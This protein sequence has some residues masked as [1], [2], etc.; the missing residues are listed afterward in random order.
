VATPQ[1]E[2]GYTRLA[3]E[4]LDEFISAGLTSR[5]W[6]VLMAIVRKTYGYNKT[7]DDIGLSQ[8]SEMTGIA[9]G[10]VSVAVRELESMKIINRKMGVFGHN[11]SINKKYK[12]WNLEAKSVTDSVTVT[13]SVTVTKSVTEGLPNQYIGGYRIGK[14][15]GTESVTTKD[16]LTK[17]NQ[18]TTPKDILASQTMRDRFNRFYSAY[19]KKKSRGQAEKAFAKLNPD[20]QLLS[21]MI[22][23]VEQS[24]KS[25]T[26]KNSQF[27]PYP[28]TW[29]NGKGWLDEI[30]TEFSGSQKAVIQAFNDA[31]GEKLG[32]IDELIFVEQRAAAIQDFLSLSSK[33]GFHTVYFDWIKDNCDLPP[34]VGFDWLINRATFTKIKGG[35]FE[36]LQTA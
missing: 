1:L 7:S 22:A 4:L 33:P 12:T 26:W 25:E 27:I 24:M 18:K 11:L 32:L 3:N 35:Q 19:P 9:K 23:G 13:E 8:L 36:R 10:H 14:K 34:R 17:D 5:Q 2:N 21:E 31:L 28:A 20:E 16:N 30:Q 29:I 6:S 15:G